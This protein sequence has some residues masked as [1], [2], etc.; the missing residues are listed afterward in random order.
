MLKSVVIEEKKFKNIESEW[1]GTRSMNDP[2]LWH[3]KLHVL[4]WL[5]VSANFYNAITP[6]NCFV[7]GS[8]KYDVYLGEE[9]KAHL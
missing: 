3:S 7:K 6:N 5:T 1:L 8:H 9:N 2:D 4:I